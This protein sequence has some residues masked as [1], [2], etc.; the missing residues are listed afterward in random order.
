MNE[1]HLINTFTRGRNRLLQMARRLLENQEDAE[2][3]L[4]EAF[5]RLWPRA[6]ML[7]SE[8]EAEKLAMVTVR[9]IS[10]DQLRRQDE[11]PSSSI[12]DQSSNPA[13]V[14]NTEEELERHEQYRIVKQL[15]DQRLTPLQQ[16]ILQM[17][18]MEDREYSEIA[19][20]E[21]M[22]EAAVRMQLSRARKTIRECYRDYQIKD[23]NYE[24]R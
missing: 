24:Q 12:E 18:D 19:Q 6:D 5:S 13:M 4:Q 14:I 22:Q 8:T 15:I 16:R 17:H 9:N 7:R 1:N 20:L 10:I 21:G 11:H 2:D 23:M 3:A